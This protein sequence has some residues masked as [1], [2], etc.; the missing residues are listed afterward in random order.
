[1]PFICRAFDTDRLDEDRIRE[2][3]S[4]TLIPGGATFFCTQVYASIGEPHEACAHVII[5]PDESWDEALDE[6]R[7]RFPEATGFRA[8]GC[9]YS[10]GR[11]RRAPA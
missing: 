3:I 8:H 1:V 4:E 11:E 5:E 2:F 6:A 7:D 10:H 9:L